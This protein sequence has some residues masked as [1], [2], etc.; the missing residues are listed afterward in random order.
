MRPRPNSPVLHRSILSGLALLL[1][2][3]CNDATGQRE[4]ETDVSAGRLAGTDARVVVEWNAL[5]YELAFAEDQFLTFKG[6]RAQAMMNLA[7]HDA[8]NTI[9][10]K[11]KRF[12]LTASHEDVDPVQ[13]A[14]HAAW[15]ILESQYPNKRAQLDSLLLLQKLRAGSGWSAA[16][17]QLG[18]AA[19]AAVLAARDADGWDNAG[20]YTFVNKPGAYQTTPDWNGFVAHPGFAQAKPFALRAPNAFRPPPPPPLQSQTY[21]RAYDEIKQQGALHSTARTADQ[22]AYAIWWLEFAEG[23][24]NRLARELVIDRSVDLWQAARL[25]AQLHVA[26]YDGYIAT[27]DAKYTYNH[28]RPY[29]AV[30]AVDDGNARTTPDPAWQSLLPVPPFPEYVSA[31]AA[32]CA[33]SFAILASVF[34]ENTSFSMTTNTAPAEMPRRSFNSFRAAADECADSRVRLGW[35]FRYATDAGLVLGRRVAKHVLQTQLRP[36]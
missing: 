24:V 3:A 6:Q 29:T 13:A 1:T 2:A 20:S 11:Y 18:A 31:H 22:S 27:W 17:A 19:A 21:V 5:A 26:L 4:L 15:A 12:V 30:R 35:H 25:F 9:S 16:G 10:P 33:A 7:M 34:S 32:A 14:A 8:L 28:W 36:N 23:S